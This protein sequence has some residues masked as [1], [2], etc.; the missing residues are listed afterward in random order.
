MIYLDNAATTGK[1]P[2]AVL[3]SVVKALKYYSANPGRSGHTLAQ[4][5]AEKVYEV[6]QKVADFFNCEG[7]E[8]VIFT[9]NCT[10]SIN[11]VLKG[12]LKRGDHVIISNLEHNAVVRPLIKT[13]VNYSVAKVDFFNDDKTL[14]EFKTK[15]KPNTKLI[16]CTAASN[17]WGRVL[18]LEKIGK[19][20]KE[21]GVLFAVDAAQG[22]GVLP[23]DM[24]KMNIDFLCVAPHKGL[25]APMG[26][27][28]LL[29]RK[30]IENT[31]LEGGSGTNSIEPF[32]PKDLPERL[33][34]GTMN[35]AGIFG[36]GSGVDY[37][38]QIG[39]EKIYN[40][41][42]SLIQYLYEK[43]KE[44]EGIILYTPYP[45]KEKFAPVL[46]FNYKD[47]PSEKLT[48]ILSKLGFAVRGGLHCAPLAHKAMDTLNSG[49]ARVSVATF[50]TKSEIDEF[51]YCFYSKKVANL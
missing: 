7:G 37:V 35:V 38:N 17:V 26:I 10:H 39:L 43:L 46:S 47:F 49:A 9:L 36:V 2:K 51:L 4:N 42:L 13:G 12:V 20:C 3:E 15:I 33:E 1:K 30:T 27:G 5:T 48:S 23:I 34:S 40:H 18:P 41:E 29:C 28:L 6:R 14:E 44:T 50:N 31:L 22:A 11:C 8:R 32:Q 21:K 19:I 16:I 24:K 45:E 25:Y